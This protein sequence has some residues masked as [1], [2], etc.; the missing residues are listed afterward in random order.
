MG[1]FKL[2]CQCAPSM[3]FFFFLKSDVW[4]LSVVAVGG[5]LADVVYTNRHSSSRFAAN[6]CSP[7]SERSL[8]RL[9]ASKTLRSPQTHK[10]RW[11][12]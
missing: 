4:H 9:K 10:K 3:L 6:L 5:N 7:F 2:T 12:I 11:M 1:G 8:G